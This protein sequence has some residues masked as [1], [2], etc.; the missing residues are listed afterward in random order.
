ML[1][2]P[3]ASALVR[4]NILCGWVVVAV[5]FPVDAGLGRSDPAAGLLALMGIFDFIGTVGS[6]WL[7]KPG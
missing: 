7:S 5:D 1:S 4:R 6:G 2:P 3:L